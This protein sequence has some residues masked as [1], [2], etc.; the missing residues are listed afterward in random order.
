MG[1]AS[2]VRLALA[3][4][5]S[6]GVNPGSGFRYM[7]M[8]SQALRHAQEVNQS[9]EIDP[10]RQPAGSLRINRSAA[11]SFAA[12]DS[13]IAPAASPGDGFD[14]LIEAAMMSDWSA[15]V[16]LTS[17]EIDIQNAS[18]GTFDLVDQHV[19][20]DAFAG[21]VVGQGIKLSGFDV[22]GTVYARI[23]VKTDDANVTVEGVRSTGVAVTNEAGQTDIAVSG[24]MIRISNTLKSYTGQVE[25]ADLSTPAYSLA[26]GLVLGQ[27]DWRVSPQSVIEHTFNFLGQLFA[28][29]TSNGAGTPAAKWATPRLTAPFDVKLKMESAFTAVATHRIAEISY[30]LDNRPRTDFEVGSDTPQVGLGTPTLQGAFNV[31]MD[32]E[33]LQQKLEGATLSKLGFLLDDGTRQRMITLPRILYTD[34]GGDAPGND[35][36]VVQQLNWA[37][38]ADANG[39]AFQIDRFA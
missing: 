15:V 38:E 11:G 32:A 35:Q 2:S 30:R 24:S 3:E 31:F 9:R 14:L 5:S 10:L 20:A 4:E 8:I 25:Y 13:L 21:F 26:T 6:Y 36:S 19:S 23:T 16:A 17:Q 27:W 28:T 12:E 39:V 37:A 29:T 7:R 1:D 18:G 33:T 34:G 22:N